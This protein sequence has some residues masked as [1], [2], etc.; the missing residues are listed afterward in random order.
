MTHKAIPQLP[1]QDFL[2]AFVWFVL[3]GFFGGGLSLN[4]VM[5]GRFPGKR[6]EVGVGE[7]SEMGCM[8]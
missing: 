2:F 3:Q 7:I 6:A 1:C 5:V 8:M 4:F